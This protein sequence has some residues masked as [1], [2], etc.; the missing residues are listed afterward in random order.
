[1]KHGNCIDTGQT[2]FSLQQQNIHKRLLVQCIPI[3]QLY[4]SHC[5]FYTVQYTVHSCQGTAM[6][7]QTSFKKHR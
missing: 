2:F 6:K 4:E 1:M 5:T 3:P 7:Y